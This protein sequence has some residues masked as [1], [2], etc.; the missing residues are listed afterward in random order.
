MIEKVTTYQ[1]T[2]IGYRFSHDAIVDIGCDLELSASTLNMAS[3]VCGRLLLKSPALTKTFV[4]VESRYVWW[5]TLS[6]ARQLSTFYRLQ[7]TRPSALITGY[8]ALVRKSTGH[9]GL[10]K[11]SRPPLFSQHAT[12]DLN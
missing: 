8:S 12:A 5:R 7:M 1:N 9:G 3:R 6:T 10:P 4:S 2:V 11:Y